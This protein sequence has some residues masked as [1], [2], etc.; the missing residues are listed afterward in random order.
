MRPLKFRLFDKTT[1]QMYEPV[2][3]LEVHHWHIDPEDVLMQFTGLLDKSGKEIYEGDIVQ[4]KHRNGKPY[5]SPATVR[6]LNNEACFTACYHPDPGTFSLLESN[7]EVIGN[8]YSNPELVSG[9][10]KDGNN[11]EK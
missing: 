9:K 8:L 11:L 2:D 5:L 7:I 10:E 6:W 4:A 3:I 1:K